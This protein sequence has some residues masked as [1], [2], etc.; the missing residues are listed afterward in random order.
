MDFEKSDPWATRGLSK[1]SA[2]LP[3][4]FG[5]KTDTPKGGSKSTGTVRLNGRC[6]KETPT[7][8]SALNHATRN[9]V[10]AIRTASVMMYVPMTKSNPWAAPTSKGF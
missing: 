9:K 7:A 3:I 4:F 6:E 8:S 10:T 1:R 5:S 2:K